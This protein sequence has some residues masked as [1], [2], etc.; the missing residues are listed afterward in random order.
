MTKKDEL[1][2]SLYRRYL[3]GVVSYLVKFGFDRDKARD[4]AQD[5]FVRVYEH[6]DSWRGEAEWAFL[7]TTAQH[8]ALNEIRSR[9][10]RKRKGAEVAI[11]GPKALELPSLDREAGA[12]LIEE[13]EQVR[14][15]TALGKAIRELPPRLRGPLELRLLGH[16][17]KS[18]AATLRLSL[19]TV[20]TRIHEAKGKLR[21][22]L[23]H[24]PE[25]PGH[26]D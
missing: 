20:K 25:E 12:R 11:D 8:V 3:P 23:G 26:E 2:Q 9:G 5:T 1:F 14:Q 13:Q 6:M 19:D 16:S 22:M 21:E 24:T 17:Y 18:I 7:R 4:L 10:T 15:A